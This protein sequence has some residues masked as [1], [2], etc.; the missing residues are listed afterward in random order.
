MVKRYGKKYHF[1]SN[2]SAI[3]YQY[4]IISIIIFYYPIML[5]VITFSKEVT[6]AC[7]RFSS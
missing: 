5:E 3:N 2:T 7:E 4:C 1:L 6:L